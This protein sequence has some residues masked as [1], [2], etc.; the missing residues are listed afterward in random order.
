MGAFGGVSANG[1]GFKK[2]LLWI[3]RSHWKSGKG[4]GFEPPLIHCI[5]HFR[6]D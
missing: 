6:F 2:M 5:L 4:C 3:S 1:F